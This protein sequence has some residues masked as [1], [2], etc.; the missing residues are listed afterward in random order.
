M[1]EGVD[2]IESA[3][4]RVRFAKRTQLNSRHLA[5]F[6]AGR[7]VDGATDVPKRDDKDDSDD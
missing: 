6:D 7:P 5:D 4:R 2:F 1:T 3:N